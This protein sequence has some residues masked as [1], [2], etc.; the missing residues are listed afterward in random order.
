MHGRQSVPQSVQLRV[1][2][3]LPLDV[4]VVDRGALVSLMVVYYAI[5][6]YDCCCCCLLLLVVIVVVVRCS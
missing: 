1:G 3:L 6:D 4:V 2:Q 5:S